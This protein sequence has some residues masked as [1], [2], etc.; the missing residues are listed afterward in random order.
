M[1]QWLGQH[2]LEQYEGSLVE[3]GFDTMDRLMMVEQE[4]LEDMV[5]GLQVQS[6]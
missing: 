3:E 5:S 1:K 2:D 4:D 6:V